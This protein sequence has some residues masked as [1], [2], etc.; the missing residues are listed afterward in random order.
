MNSISKVLKTTFCACEKSRVEDLNYCWRNLG[1]KFKL[2]EGACQSIVHHVE[3]RMEER[4]DEGVMVFLKRERASWEQ[5]SQVWNSWVVPRL[6]AK[7]KHLRQAQQQSYTRQ[8]QAAC[9]ICDN[10]LVNCNKEL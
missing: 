4:V 6:V 5:F 1:N 9:V 7:G 8:C 3:F 2:V 10:K